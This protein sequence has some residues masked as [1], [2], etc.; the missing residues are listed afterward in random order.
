MN[1]EEYMKA[2][3]YKEDLRKAYENSTVLINPESENEI[4]FLLNENISKEEAA[5]LFNNFPKELKVNI[6]ISKKHEEELETVKIKYEEFLSR[7]DG[8]GMGSPSTGLSYVDVIVNNLDLFGRY[9]FFPWAIKKILEDIDDKIWD[10]IKT[11]FKNVYSKFF[12][13]NKNKNIAFVFWID[14]KQALFIFN[15]NF[16]K[17]II[18]D[19]LENVPTVLKEIKNGK[20]V[21][22]SLIFEIN[23]N[24]G[25]WVQTND[26]YIR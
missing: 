2:E 20:Y 1:T 7:V 13:R 15:L 18:M 5:S 17:E 19:S 12:K 14:S 11:S 4:S 26:K 24:T 8:L 16:K 22:L 25:K 10:K 21:Y 6:Y 23:E 3:E 9:I